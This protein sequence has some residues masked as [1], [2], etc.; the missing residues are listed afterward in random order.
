MLLEDRHVFRCAKELGNRVLY[1]IKYLVKC[2]QYFW[3]STYAGHQLK[4]ARLS[5]L[6]QTNDVGKMGR[7]ILLVA[8]DVGHLRCQIV[9][10]GV[11]DVEFAWRA[12]GQESIV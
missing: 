12:R 2:S 7:V 10:Q 8:A 9:A 11:V 1:S 3:I 5:K 4:D 6:K